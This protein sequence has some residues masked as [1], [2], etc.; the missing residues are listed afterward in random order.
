MYL[1]N[2][3]DNECVYCGFK[4]GNGIGRKTLTLDE[5]ERE[6]R[7]IS[8]GGL[9]SILV[10]TGAS[11]REAPVSYIRSCVRILSKYF[12][13]ISIE[14]YEL[15]SD[16]YA[17]LICEGVDGLVIYQEVYDEQ[18]YRQVH[19]SG[20]K[21]NYEFR[22][23]APERALSAGIRTVNIGALL[24]LGDWRREIFFTALHARYLEK[25]FPAAEISVSVPRIRPQVSSFEPRSRV[26]D[27]DLVQIVASLRLFLPRVGITLSTRERGSLRDILVSVG[28][29]RMSAGSTTCVGGHTATDRE[30][31]AEQFEIFDSR[32]VNEIKDMLREKGY[33]PVLKDWV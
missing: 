33:Q 28:I 29:T 12:S 17:E 13:S 31:R 25:K 15:T 16:E 20:A 3:C 9:R 19:I 22:I 18:I 14:V 7:F 32:G 30:D 5:V 27:K 2:F 23:G 26:T 24:G 21:R 10:L 8:S 6:A 11:R 4:K 1:S